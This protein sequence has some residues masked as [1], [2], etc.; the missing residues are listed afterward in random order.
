MEVRDTFKYELY[1][2]TEL[3]YV[4]I[5]N[6]LDRRT[7]E[8]R[9]EGYKFTH[10]V[11]VGYISTRQSAG[12]WEEERI[13]TYMENHGGKLPRYNSNSTGKWFPLIE[14]TQIHCEKQL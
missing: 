7:A 14:S 10:V 3:V 6:D 5:T 11:P 1:D 4:G 9:N 13:H 8:H 12:E 2:G